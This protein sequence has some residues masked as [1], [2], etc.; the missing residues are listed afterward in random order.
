MKK[1]NPRDLRI[2]IDIPVSGEPEE[3]EPD[4][5]ERFLIEFLYWWKRYNYGKMSTFF[6]PDWCEGDTIKKQ[7]GETRRRF[8]TNN[9]IEFALEKVIDK[10]PAI[11]VIEVKLK[12]CENGN[13][14]E[15]SVGFRLVYENKQGFPTMRGLKDAE[16][17]L[18]TYFV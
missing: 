3:Y 1:W 10:A 11:T 12:Y 5:P 8:G 4:S 18:H 16:W 17:R 13:F 14:H 2:G 9:L 15:K 6:P 7:A